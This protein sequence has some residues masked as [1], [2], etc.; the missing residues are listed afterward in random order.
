M[1]LGLGLGAFAGVARLLVEA[2]E[3]YLA[4]ALLVGLLGNALLGLWWLDPV[5]T[6]LI[7]AVRGHR[8]WHGEGC[9]CAAA[10]MRS[11]AKGACADDWCR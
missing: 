9:A 6:L 8:M 7:A 5:V 3:N 4:G 2:V 1:S 10:P 11:S